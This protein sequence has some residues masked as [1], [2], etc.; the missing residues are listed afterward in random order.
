MNIL[1]SCDEYP[2][3]CTGGIGTATKTVAEGLVRKGHTVVVV[4]GWLPTHDLP[5]V[6]KQNGVIVYRLKYFCNIP[7]ICNN[8][9]LGKMCRTILAKTGIL[10]SLAI[11]EYNRTAQYINELIDKHNIDVIELPDYS[12]LTKYIQRQTKIEYPKY[13]VPV[14]GRVH[15]N[16][17]FLSYNKSGNLYAITKD[18]DKRFFESCDK[19]LSVSKFAADFVNNTLEVEKNIDVIYNPMNANFIVDDNEI[20]DDR[21]KNIIFIGKIIETKGAFN[22]LRAYNSFSQEH[23]DYKLIM[24]GGGEI[25]QGKLLVPEQLCDRVEFTGF[26]DSVHVREYLKTAAFCVVP[27][28]FETLGQGAIEMMGLGNILI[29]ANTSTGPEI[30]TDGIDGFLV[31][32]Y[33][34]DAIHDKMSYVATNI[35]ELKEVRHQAARTVRERFAEDIV[36]SQLEDYYKSIC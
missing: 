35:D 6:S 31:D 8:G 5:F 16:E 20:N 24:I 27:S 21:T 23:P 26:V 33:V 36:I 7:F 17:S 32:P 12:I 29:Y 34:V 28:F 9:I 19:I 4:S 11:K 18:N 1:F 14:V 13:K 2:P 25:E 22:L 30:I 3:L 10:T 15:G